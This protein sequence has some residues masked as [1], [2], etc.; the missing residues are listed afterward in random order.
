MQAT[1]L[2]LDSLRMLR[3]RK[4][5]WISLGIS[6]LVMLAYAS[7][8]FGENGLSLF[9]GAWE[10]EDPFFVEGSPWAKALYLGIYSNLVVTIWLSWAA[11]ILALVS[12]SSV[13]PDFMSA[14]SIE[15]VL[16]KPIS[17]VR[18][19]LIKFIGS[20]L[21]VFVQVLLFCTGVFIC[22]GIR[23][24]EWIWP[25]FAAVPLV[26]IFFSYLYAF[27]VLMGLVTRSGLAALLFTALFWFLLFAVQSGE[28]ALSTIATEQSVRLERLE[29]RMADQQ[30]R[31]DRIAG[32]E[33]PSEQR[34]RERLETELEANRTR[35]DEARQRLEAIEGWHRPLEIAMAVLPKNQQTIGLLDRWLAP[36]SRYTMTEIMLGEYREEEPSA[37]PPPIEE[38][39][40]PTG[41]ESREARREERRETQRESTR[42][43]LGEDRE[44]SAWFIIGSS[45]A[46]EAAILALAAFIFARRDF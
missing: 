25:I 6:M 4:L 39:E 36:D 40:E 20:L 29:D 42:R 28:G 46:F 34:A 3:S 37:P 35:A 21:F 11:T 2:L 19:F 26:T 44:T 7:I 17:R 27:N 13:F 31:L 23:I 32:S 9:F 43:E 12:T 38:T 30:A 1:A 8:G 45:L 14:G 10:L 5:F 33:R 41:E 16:S 15:M 24:D 22:V 18:V